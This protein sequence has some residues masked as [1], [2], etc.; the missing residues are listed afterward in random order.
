L[1]I[2]LLYAQ[3]SGI[4]RNIRGA[5]CEHIFATPCA[6]EL[7]LNNAAKIMKRSGTCL[8][9]IGTSALVLVWSALEGRSANLLVNPSFADGTA[10][11][12][13]SGAQRASGAANAHN[14]DGYSLGFRDEWIAVGTSATATQTLP[15]APNQDWTFSAWARNSSAAALGVPDYGLLEII[16]TTGSGTSTFQSSHID[17]NSLPQ[18]TWVS[19]SKTAIA[20]LGTTEV[21]FRASFF[22]GDDGYA[23]TRLYFDDFSAVSSIPEP[24]VAF[25]ASA[26]LAAVVLVV[27]RS[28]KAKV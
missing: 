5:D 6:L 17:L 21:S 28:R 15:S 18:D 16:F 7:Q 23:N 24:H 12:V 25:V 19:F 20:P 11:W 22:R 3:L 26:V 9:T 13:L 8:A 14:T 27:H 2:S 10:P 4:G 1:T